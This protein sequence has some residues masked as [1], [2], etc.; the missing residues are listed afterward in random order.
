MNYFLSLI[1]IALAYFTVVIPIS[2]FLHELGHAA[3]IIFSTKSGQAMLFMGPI[4]EQR[5]EHFRL[6]RIHFHLKWASF[7]F[8][9]ITTNTR[10]SPIQS[11]IMDAGGPIMNLVISL[12]A[13]FI[14]FSFSGHFLYLVRAAAFYNFV[15]FL[16]TALPYKY[17]M[18]NK[19]FAG[20][21]TDGYRIM[22]TVKALIKK[23]WK[24]KMIK[25]S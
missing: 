16:S 14:S 19:A 22:K 7:G 2:V 17:S 21:D 5:K 4:N 24:L 8:C 12:I 18:K 3:G 6:G 23:R 13:F 1:L 20:L 25:H 15:A 10:V 9:Y 11:I